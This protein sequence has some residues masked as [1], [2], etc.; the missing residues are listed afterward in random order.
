MN[1]L[2]SVAAYIVLAFFFVVSAPFIAAG[3]I[4][5]HIAAFWYCGWSKAAKHQE[6]IS[7][8]HDERKAK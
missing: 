1:Y 5:N 8:L 4:A 3:Y 7:K 6:Y 2:I